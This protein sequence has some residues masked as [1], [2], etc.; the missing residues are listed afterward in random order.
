MHSANCAD[1]A[2]SSVTIRSCSLTTAT[3]AGPLA[4]ILRASATVNFASR[5]S[6]CS[7]DAGTLIGAPRAMGFR[8]NQTGDRT[9]TAGRSLVRLGGHPYLVFMAEL[10]VA[11]ADGA[12]SRRARVLLSSGPSW[13]QASAAEGRERAI[14][15]G[16][17]RLEHQACPGSSDHRTRSC[18]SIISR[19]SMENQ[20]AWLKAAACRRPAS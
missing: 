15:T 1:T 14:G 3:D 18:R 20:A 13:R 6:P 12:R 7:V 16:S 17:L 19:A 10:R 9:G 4:V 11:P 2:S 8:K 5:T